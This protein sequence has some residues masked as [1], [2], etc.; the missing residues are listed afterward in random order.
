MVQG[1][2]TMEAKLCHNYIQKLETIIHEAFVYQRGSLLKTGFL[3]TR[4]GSLCTEK[5]L[6]LGENC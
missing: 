1:I 4:N 2:V 6:A 5:L 3:A